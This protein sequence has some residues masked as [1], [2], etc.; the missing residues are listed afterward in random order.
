MSAVNERAVK[1]HVVSRVVLAEFTVDR[2]L[3]VEDCP[4]PDGGVAALR[5]RSGMSTTS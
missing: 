3:E 1:Q 2:L 4:S 5:P